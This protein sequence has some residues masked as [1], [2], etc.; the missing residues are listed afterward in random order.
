MVTPTPDSTATINPAPTTPVVQ[1]VV[2][3][4]SVVSLRTDDPAYKPYID[5]LV[6]L[7]NP[8]V[9]N[10]IDHLCGGYIQ[11]S[12]QYLLA[13]TKEYIYKRLNDCDQDEFDMYMGCPEVGHLHMFRL[14]FRDAITDTLNEYKSRVIN[15]NIS[16][17]FDSNSSLISRINSVLA[18]VPSLD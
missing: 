1:P 9:V 15:N 12:E 10:R 3:A 17:R 2:Q 18:R 5:E 4:P 6:E 13:T 16:T 7:V 8:W 14:V 11:Y